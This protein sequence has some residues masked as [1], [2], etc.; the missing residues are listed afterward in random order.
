MAMSRVADELHAAS[1][2][3]NLLASQ[4][5][6]AIAA[7]G[8]GV[9]FYAALADV[10]AAADLLEEHCDGRADHAR[11]L[12][13]LIVTTEWLAWHAR[14]RRSADADSADRRTVRI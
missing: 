11:A 8:T 1:E 13:T 10:A 6:S 9:N 5:R 4:V 2:G 12:W 3:Q 14:C 7:Y